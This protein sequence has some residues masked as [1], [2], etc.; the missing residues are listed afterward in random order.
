[1]KSVIDDVLMRLC[2]LD[3]SSAFYGMVENRSCSLRTTDYVPPF[4][5]RRFVSSHP[6]G[7]GL[8]VF[9]CCFRWEGL[10]GCAGEGVSYFVHFFFPSFFVDLLTLCRILLM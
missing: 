3:G 4:V 10:W 7:F 6:A 9:L 2:D 1:M 5:L 8:P